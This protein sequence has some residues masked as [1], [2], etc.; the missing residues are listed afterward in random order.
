[1]DY[2][3]QSNVTERYGTARIAQLTGDKTGTTIDETKLAGFIADVSVVFDG[4]VG[5]QCDLPFDADKIPGVLRKLAIEEVFFELKKSSISGSN[6]VSESLQKIHENTMKILR[7]IARGEFTLGIIDE[8]SGERVAKP[9]P[10]VAFRS[11]RRLF[12]RDA[13]YQQ[14]YPEAE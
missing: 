12:G 13:G 14:T 3:T 1:M 5:K 4:Y 2:C 9:R 6:A 10:T 7:E 8:D 11:N